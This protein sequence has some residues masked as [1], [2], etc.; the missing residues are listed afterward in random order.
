MLTGLGALQKPLHAGDDV[1]PGRLGVLAV[2]HEHPH[3]VGVVAPDVSDVLLH[4]NSVVVASIERG[5]STGVVDAD[6]E[7]LGAPGPRAL[8]EPGLGGRHLLARREL[9]DLLVRLGPEKLLHFEQE[10]QKGRWQAICQDRVQKQ[11]QKGASGGSELEEEGGGRM[12]RD[13]GVV[14]ER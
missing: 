8:Q 1:G 10:L 7:G 4:R 14:G 11:A 5:R 9:G 3:V 2:I 12:G 13:R 6:E